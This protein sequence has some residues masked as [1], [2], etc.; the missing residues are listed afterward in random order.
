MAEPARATGSEL[1][2]PPTIPGAVED[3]GASYRG[4]VA[5]A[6]LPH[7]P[8]RGQGTVTRGK[9][10]AWQTQVTEGGRKNGVGDL[11]PDIPTQSLKRGDSKPAQG[12]RTCLGAGR[13][14][15]VALGSARGIAGATHDE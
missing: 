9:S 13:R 15:E 3:T 12:G 14:S 4:G 1:S 2:H 6:L 5:S 8:P 11:R 7:C 10:H